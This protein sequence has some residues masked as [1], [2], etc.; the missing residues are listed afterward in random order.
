MVLGDRPFLC[1]GKI[2][3]FGW[4]QGRIEVEKNPEITYNLLYENKE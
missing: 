1:V 4:I 3:G 2:D